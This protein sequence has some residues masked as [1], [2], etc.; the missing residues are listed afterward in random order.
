MVSCRMTYEQRAEV[1]KNAVSQQLLKLMTKKK[2]NLAIAADVASTKQ[3]LALADQV[4]LSTHLL[5]R[6]CMSQT[7]LK[8]NDS[9][10]ARQGALAHALV[11]PQPDSASLPGSG[12]CHAFDGFI[13]IAAAEYARADCNG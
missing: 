2:S 10:C 3:L 11:R 6:Y 1:A 9:S 5:L 4:C 13:E 12:C 8:S 7:Q